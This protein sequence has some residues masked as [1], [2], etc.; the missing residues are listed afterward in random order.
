MKQ[1]ALLLLLSVTSMTQ[2]ACSSELSFETEAEDLPKAV[3]ASPDAPKDRKSAVHIANVGGTCSATKLNAHVLLSASHCF[4]H[5]TKDII[6]NDQPAII[7]RIQQDGNDHALVLLSGIVM[8]DFATWGPPSAEGD[9]IHYW[10]S[11]FVYTMLLRRGYV[12]GFLDTSTIYDSNSYHGDSG[13]GVFDNKNRLVGV[14]SY[15]HGHNAFSVMGAFPL[16]FTESQL[17]DVGLTPEPRLTTGVASEVKLNY[18][19]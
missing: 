17:A 16:N 14:V 9:A 10:G 8:S 3:A 15:I 18:G 4:R 12:S 2:T 5:S 11:P 13:A 7:E 19:D 1:F 6:I